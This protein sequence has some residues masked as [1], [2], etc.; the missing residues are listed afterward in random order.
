MKHN[1]LLFLL[2]ASLFTVSSGTMAADATATLSQM[3]SPVMVNQGDS[4]DTATEGMDLKSGDQIM[5]M[6]GG[7]AKVQFANGCE[8]ELN[9]NDVY[10]ITD[11]SECDEALAAAGGAAAAGTGTGTGAG[12]GTAAAA[13]GGGIGTGTLALAGLALGGA[14]AATS[15]GGSSS[16]NNPPASP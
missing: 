1:A 16:N 9:A 2:T 14:V 8:I 12:A 13:T 7:S 4:Y 15:G 5:V 10:R 6:E 11:S 3:G